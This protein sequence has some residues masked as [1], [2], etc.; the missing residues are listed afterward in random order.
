MQPTSL[1]YHYEKNIFK[2]SKLKQFLKIIEKQR[3]SYA[4][5][6]KARELYQNKNNNS[7]NDN[8]NNNNNNDNNNNN[9]YYYYDYDYY[10]YYYYYY[11]QYYYY[12]IIQPALDLLT[13]SFT[14]TRKLADK[15]R[16][17]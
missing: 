7:N 9:N 15:L 1:Q 16:R 14:T 3:I 4:F 2:F 6:K 8:N 13:Q 5:A 10:Y 12:F 17:V 11:Y